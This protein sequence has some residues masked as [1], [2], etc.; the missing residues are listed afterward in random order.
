[1]RTVLLPLGILLPL[2]ACRVEN[3]VD[4][5]PD[6]PPPSTEDCVPADETCDGLDNDCD[7]E[8]D[9]GLSQAWLPDDDADGYGSDA[10]PVDACAAPEGHVAEGGD[11]DDQDAAVN[12]GADERCNDADDDCDGAA[13]EELPLGRWY[14]DADGDGWGDPSLPVEDC[15][16]PEGTTELLSDCDDADAARHLC[17]SCEEILARGLSSGDGDY[18]IDTPECGSRT[19]YCDM[20]TDGG[21]WT[22]VVSVSFDVDACPGDWQPVDIGVARV[23]ARSASGG[24][25]L[26]RYATFD[27]CGLPYDAVRGNAVMYQNGSTDAFGDRPSTSL[28]GAYGDVVSF[29]VGSPRAHVFS[30]AF[31]Y[32]AGGSDDSNC[33]AI[34]G[35]SPPGFVDDAYLCATGNPSTSSNANVWYTT[36]LFGA[37]WFQVALGA[38]VTDDLEGRLIG[39]HDTSDEDVGVAALRLQVR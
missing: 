6:D 18:E 32:L 17:L 1:M 38:E 36:P 26:L 4:G 20:T 15:A 10:A 30:Y 9:E 5:L 21:G 29:T 19:V 27:T 12:P 39:T 11:C 33:P 2:A 31:G 24:T 7:G 14:T 8:I 23:C 35:A 37:D 25:G 3:K 16:P 13:D 22:E 34:G 28:D